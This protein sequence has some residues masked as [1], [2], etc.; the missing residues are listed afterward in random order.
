M[1][2]GAQSYTKL[3]GGSDEFASLPNERIKQLR[4][5]PQR[6][7]SPARVWV[8]VCARAASECDPAIRPVRTYPWREKH[9]RGFRGR[10]FLLLRRA[11][12][13]GFRATRFLSVRPVWYRQ[14][15]L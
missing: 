14:T 11:K 13:P 4:K 6:Q 5:R 9:Q 8:H 15:Q 2:Q 1:V 3:R 12:L 7:P 10:R